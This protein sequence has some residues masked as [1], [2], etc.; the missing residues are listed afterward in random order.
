MI[1]HEIYMRQAIE[2]AEHNVK[3]HR[4]GPFGAIVVHNN[5]II[6]IGTNLVTAINDPTAHAEIIAIRQACKQLNNYQLATCILYSSCEPCPMCFGALYWARVDRVY[7][8]ATKE[9]ASA[10]GFDDSYI[11]QQMLVPADNRTITMIQIM[12]NEAL[13][14]FTLWQN[15]TEKIMY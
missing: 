9:D 12:R 15:T 7:Y 2:L 3:N 11:Y 10:I 14:V 1:E 13:P 8:A 4:G 6:G 5:H